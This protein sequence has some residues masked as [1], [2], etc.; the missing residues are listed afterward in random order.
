[1]GFARA[2][3]AD[4]VAEGLDI[5]TNSLDQLYIG[6]ALAHVD[7]WR[8][9][10]ALVE[11]RRV[12]KVGGILRLAVPDVELAMEAL[13]SDEDTFFWS[14]PTVHLSG[15]FA[16]QCLDGGLARSLFTKPL[17]GELL[18]RAGFADIRTV[19]GGYST[20]DTTLAT[21]D[22]FPDHDVF[23]EA[24]NPT[25]WPSAPMPAG[26]A[27]VHL[28]FGD[29]DC[30]TVD[31]VWTGPPSTSGTLHYRQAGR[32]DW[33][34]VAA[35]SWPTVDGR[36]SPHVFC[37]SCSD[38]QPGTEYEYEV[39]QRISGTSVGGDI[40]RFRTLPA[41]R[42]EPITFAFIADTGLAGRPDGLSDGVDLV[43]E[44]VEK[45]APH[46]VLGG[47]DYAY[48]SSDPRLDGGQQAVQAWLGQISLI[49]RRRP[50]IPQW[51]NHEV[52]L[53]EYWRDWVA[54]FPRQ[55]RVL[56]E[57]A[58]RSHSF[59]AGPCHVVAFYAPTA[60]I[61]PRELSWL[62]S[63]LVDA[64]ARGLPWL[65][66]F[67]HQPLISRGTSHPA[68][69]RVAEALGHVL[70]TCGVDL[71]LSA[72][73]QNYERTHPLRWD[74]GRLSA[75]REGPASYAQ[76]DGLICAKVSPAGK[77]SDIG[78][79]FS[80]LPVSHSELVATAHSGAHHVAVVSCTES[81]LDMAIHA[82]IGSEGSTRLVDSVVISRDTAGPRAP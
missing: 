76:G 72:H 20:A 52:D 10:D 18:R 82:G 80:Q 77:R 30:R 33:T 31:V 28:L 63:D 34:V 17:C 51:G 29:H 15:A 48:K 54:H 7:Q 50:V 41:S 21:P 64:R 14:H 24:T 16:L 55:G 39:V 40:E 35:S 78:R 59:D 32:D 38:L 2:N 4:L 49:A 45:A 43:H 47:G 53:G 5:P 26:P 71:H 68:D 6:R 70:F 81:R 62:W 56:P 9:D 36:L 42:D 1:M 57:S 13:Q 23:T 79:S 27:G 37:A 25:A 60:D 3:A 67:Q 73:D 69:P 74:D 61:R 58:N 46:F 12:L 66:V 75:A 8:L 11:F 19:S 65:V 44:I 22:R